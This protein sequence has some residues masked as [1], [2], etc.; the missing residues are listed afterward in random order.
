[1]S[2]ARARAGDDPVLDRL[3]QLVTQLAEQIQNGDGGKAFQ[4]AAQ[5]FQSIKD[6]PDQVLVL[7]LKGLLKIVEGLA[8]VALQGFGLVLGAFFDAVNAA[9]TAVQSLLNERWTIPVVSDIYQWATDS[10]DGS[11][12]IIE[13]TALMAAIPATSIYKATFGGAPFPD[14]NAVDAVK[15][16][17]T[18]GWLEQRAWGG[19]P[20]IAAPSDPLTEIRRICNILYAVNFG[21]RCPV[22]FAIN[23]NAQPLLPLSVINIGQRFFASGLS[24]P[25]VMGDPEGPPFPG[26]A[27]GWTQWIWITQ[28]MFGPTRGAILLAFEV[29]APAGD[30]SLSIWGVVRWGVEA[31]LAIAEADENK[32]NAARTTERMLVC[33]GPQFCKFLHVPDVVAWTDRASLPAGAWTNLAS[34]LGII[35]LHAART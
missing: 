21:V 8:L 16:L 12:S 10:K 15:R 5:Y 2:P 4:Q 20:G 28:I 35:S 14:D 11:F 29:E 13:L 23:Y 31:I 34:E 18:V 25:W 27:D 7:S 22:E 17:I 24:I 6:N 3:V 9:I 33:F 19:G 32:S 30:L 1:L 26:T